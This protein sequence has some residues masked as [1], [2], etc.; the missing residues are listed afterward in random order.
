MDDDEKVGGTESG[1]KQS[2]AGSSGSEKKPGASGYNIDTS[3][4]K[5]PFRRIVRSKMGKVI[6]R[7][8]RTGM[9]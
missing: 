5:S 6:D 8:G 1:Q 3:G 9:P 4:Y 7:T 2:Q